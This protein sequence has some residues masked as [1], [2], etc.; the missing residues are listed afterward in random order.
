[1]IAVS[2]DSNP[3]LAVINATYFSTNN[4]TSDL[5]TR[6]GGGVGASFIRNTIGYNGWAARGA[7]AL[8][9]QQLTGQPAICYD[10]RY[11]SAFLPMV[12]GTLAI[13]LWTIFLLVKSYLRDTNKMQARYGG[14]APTIGPPTF[15]KLSRHTVL[16]WE[17]EPDAHLKPT[18][19]RTSSSWFR[20]FVIFLNVF[21]RE[22]S[23]LHVE[24]GLVC[25]KFCTSVS[26]MQ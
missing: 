7:Q 11:G 9:V 3:A 17:D 25:Y 23:T 8:T 1:M 14:L 15:S 16:V 18:T 12:L 5:L 24:S 4:F 2:S 13:V 22:P 19:T 6:W 20:K 26:H 21:P 10:L